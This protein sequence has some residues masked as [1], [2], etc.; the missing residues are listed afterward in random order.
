MSGPWHLIYC[1][2]PG[3]H[4]LLLPPPHVELFS[5][6]FMQLASPPVDNEANKQCCVFIAKQLGIARRQV[7]IIRGQTSRHKVRRVEG[8]VEQ[9]VQEK[10]LRKDR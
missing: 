2:A 3:L 9:E 5:I 1:Q 10:L 8:V 6:Y 4:P 7:A